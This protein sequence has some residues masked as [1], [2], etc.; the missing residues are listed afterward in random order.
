MIDELLS[1]TK[2]VGSCI[3]WQGAKDGKGY[4]LIRRFGRLFKT[5]RLMYA[6]VHGADLLGLMVCHTCDTPSCINPEHLWLG[7]NSDNQQ[8]A[9][10]KGRNFN[11]KK[12]HCNHGHE[13]TKE[14]TYL[15][16]TER[17]CRTCARARAKRWRDKTP[18]SA[19]S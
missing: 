6:E 7:S 5:H 14:N 4:G 3:L 2:K 1:R 16:R 19:R 12:T 9:V 17:V 10:Q 18:R 15:V 11:V 13:F 8:D